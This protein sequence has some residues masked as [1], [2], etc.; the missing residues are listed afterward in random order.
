MGRACPKPL[1]EGELE[2]LAG[3]MEVDPSSPSGLCRLKSYGKYKAGD[4]VGNLAPSGYWKAHWHYQGQRRRR[5]C[6]TLVLELSGKP[7]PGEDFTADHLDRNRSNN[8]VDNLGWVT[9]TEQSIN[10]RSWTST[11][12]RYVSQGSSSFFYQFWLPGRSKLIKKRGFTT[13]AEAY[14]A[15]VRMREQLGLDGPEV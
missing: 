4:P 12:Y 6:H 15:A 5:S 13:A 3:L 11:G 10:R 2:F 9:C 1:L 7:L 14:A 8:A